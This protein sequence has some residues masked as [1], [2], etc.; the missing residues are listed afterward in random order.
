MPSAQHMIA[1]IAPQDFKAWIATQGEQVTLL[2]CREAWE[3]QTASVKADG[4]ALLHI[5]MNDTPSRLGELNTDAPVAVLCHHGARS[6]RVAMYLAQ[7]GF[8]NVANL[9]GGIAAWSRAVDAS[10]PQY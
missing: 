4:F 3:L 5:P 8:G 9:A 2:D 6:Q 7:N 1:Q 10:V